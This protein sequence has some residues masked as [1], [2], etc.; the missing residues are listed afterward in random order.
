MPPI[1]RRA[2]CATPRMVL[3]GKQGAHREFR[4]LG[5]MQK[6]AANQ[7]LGHRRED[8]GD[9]TDWRTNLWE[10]LQLVVT[11]LAQLRQTRRLWISLG[12]I[13]PRFV[14]RELSVVNVIF[15]DELSW[16]RSRRRRS[17]YHVL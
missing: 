5:D 3:C 12:R 1:W 17:K 6:R 4:P 8:P 16:I 13:C 7:V 15:W 10:N 11:P 2:F 9:G 14:S